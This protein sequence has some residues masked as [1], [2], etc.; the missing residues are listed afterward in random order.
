MAKSWLLLVALV[1]LAPTADAQ[2]KFDNRAFTTVYLN[3]LCDSLNSHPDRLI[4]DVRSP[5]EFADSLHEVRYNIGHLKGAVNIDIN[6]L[7]KR[8]K[9]IAAY[10]NKPI[11]I[12]CSHSQRSRTGSKMLADSGFTQVYNINGAMTWVNLLK[13]TQLPCLKNLYET[14]NPFTL[15]S[16]QE[17]LTLIAS[18]KEL[19]LLDVRNDSAFRGIS[20]DASENVLG[21]LNNSVNIPLS[22]LSSSLKEVPANRPIL[23]V[24]DNGNNVNAAAKILTDNG[25]REVYASFN[26]LMQWLSLPAAA[27]QGSQ[28]VW[29]RPSP[30]TTL[31]AE[32]FDQVMTRQPATLL[33]DIR[34]ETEF[35]NQEKRD[36]W[37]NRGHLSNALNI[38]GNV[39]GSRLAE[40]NEHRN[41]PIILYTFNTSPEVFEAAKLLAVNGF[42]NV[43]VLMGGIW[44]LR[45]KAAN[46]KGL[47]HLK[48]WVVDV[49]E[50]NL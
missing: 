27:L 34:P 41:K 20:R 28:Q 2:Y 38:P 21:R 1:G 26:G 47:S 4:L 12:Y 30:F 7:G 23:V 49:P 25:F 42:T 13:D 45:W 16:P 50:D 15:V 24:A 9:E 6:E 22:R 46:I 36:T 35:T 5:G 32:E 3:D 39:L 43:Q 10:K 40:I 29:V 37:R 14:R 18:K 8:W 11:F 48:N 31:T 33:L 17:A 19:F 44:D